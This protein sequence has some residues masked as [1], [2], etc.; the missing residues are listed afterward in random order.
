MSS[1][2]SSLSPRFDYI[3]IWGH[4]LKYRDGIL[5]IIENTSGIEILKCFN[6]RPE[7]ISEFVYRI[8]SF[9]YAPF[10]HL[11]NKVN[12]LLSTPK[13]VLFIFFR[14]NDPE[15]DYHGDGAFRHEESNTIRLLKEVI[16]NK[17][18]PLDR[19]GQR[20]EEHVIHAS[21]CWE[22]TDY[23]LRL[24]GYAE[25]VKLL[26]EQ[27]HWIGVPA[28]LGETDNFLV[29][30]ISLDDL[31]AT[32]NIGDKQK[33]SRIIDTPH[34][35][36]IKYD[37]NIYK[38]YLDKYFG[39]LLTDYYSVSKY[40]RLMENLGDPI[41][42]PLIAVKDIEGQYVIADGVHRASIYKNRG[43]DK[44]PVMILGAE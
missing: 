21:D 4:G 28:H 29:R 26:Q 5:D 6:Y 35:R 43:L 38:E 7:S 15:V 24:L 17:Y 30:I 22:Q 1:F 41:D 32:I 37:I 3:L 19:N 40:K 2:V 34:F 9:D 10:Q 27:F 16:R 11:E 44:I 31:Y 25:G 18:N 12:Y 14:N 20:S 33:I 42:E 36:G 39:V 23:A 13:E 8:Y